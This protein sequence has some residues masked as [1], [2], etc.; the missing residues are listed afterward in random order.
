MQLSIV[1][2]NFNV[3]HF[4]EQCLA[5]VR[6]AA[7][8]LDVEVIV[9]DN[10]S[11]DNSL[12]YLQPDFPE[13][14]FVASPVNQ[15]FAK[16]CNQGWKMGSGKYVLFLNPDTLL[17]E[18]TLSR[19]IRFMENTPDAGAL[20][21][22]M[23]DGTGRFLKESKRAFPSPIISLYKLAGLAKLFP[24]SPV[25]ARY[26]LGHLD[27]NKNHAVDVLAGAYMMV[28]RDLLESVDG[29]D[30]QFFMYGEDV[31]LSYRL[32]QQPCPAGGNYRN[33]Y[34]S[35]APIIHFKGEST[36]KAS[37][38]YV[39]M[40]YVA[41][42]Q[43]VKKHYG[44][45][46]AGTFNFFIHLAIWMRA[47]F[48]AF[49]RFIRVVG[50][51]LLDAGLILLSFWLV[52]EIWSAHIKPEVRYEE[53]M[54]WIAFPAFS[55]VYLITAYYA[56]LYDRWYRRVELIQSTL[57]ATLVVLATYALL[58]E[59]YRFSR[60]M[61]LFGALMAFLL[62]G[63][64]RRI[65]V[66][67]RV[68]ANHKPHENPVS[69]LVV[70]TQLEYQQVKEL[71]SAANMEQKLLGR[72][73]VDDNTAGTLGRWPGISS[74][75]KT[76]PFSELILVSGKLD[77]RELISNLPNIS[78]HI[79]IKWH[80]QGTRSIIGSDSKDSSGESLSHE[81]GYRITNPHYRRLKR[82]ADVVIAVIG[83][84]LWPVWLFVVRKPFRFLGNCF[85][86]LLAQKSWMGYASAQTHL[87]A[88]RPGVLGSNGLSLSVN[89]DLPRES[90]EL[91]DFWY[92]R[93]Y[94]MQAELRKILYSWRN[95][96]A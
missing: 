36:R 77:Y 63:L 91:L 38:N 33:Y 64:L 8:G 35:E 1:I 41:M 27:E 34:F 67:A 73:A 81:N 11:D 70:G 48:S 88:I 95:L 32:Q 94:S 28:R 43:F 24:R 47:A 29:F 84:L 54:L 59:Q 71:L 49:S 15:G 62:I 83:I 5:S 56:G 30:E 46:R 66:A 17:Q 65:L 37:M 42:S 9:V 53:K 50:L 4:L 85:Q 44:A 26:H 61:I 45:S 2:V 14:T 10:A 16:A 55:V 82:L 72:I 31:D 78:R 12:A 13:V 80:R 3:K 39:R 20:G 93:D 57:V 92:A 51:P 86:V 87:P 52:K 74:L 7:K 68:L 25:F 96:G 79:R 75:R 40:F 19:C 6:A 58:P 23:L 69:T 60:G 89:K 76:I 18:D 90:L 22:K 21:V